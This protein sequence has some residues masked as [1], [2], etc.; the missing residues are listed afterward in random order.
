MRCSATTK[1]ASISLPP[2]HPSATRSAA[3]PRARCACSPRRGR[4]H[5]CELIERD[6]GLGLE[7]DFVGHARLLAALPVL[8]PALR[9]IEA[10][11]YGQAGVVIGHRQRHCD[12]AVLLLAELPAILMRHA[13]RMRPMLGKARV[14]DDP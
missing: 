6:L 11:G 10:I 5:P 7:A 1:R 3:I 2:S 13:D 14:V 12:L 8:R 4:A 9:Q